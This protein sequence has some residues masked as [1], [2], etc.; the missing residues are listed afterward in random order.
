LLFA[1]RAG[2]FAQA[3][4]QF[5]DGAIAIAQTRVELTFAQ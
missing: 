2:K 5:L 3:Q 4:I 1:Q